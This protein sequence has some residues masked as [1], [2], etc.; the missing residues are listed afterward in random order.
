MKTTTYPKTGGRGEGGGGSIVDNFTYL[1]S[2]A[3][4]LLQNIATNKSRFFD[5]AV[6]Q[7]AVCNVTHCQNEGDDKTTSRVM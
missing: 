1:F 5:K 7:G 6:P 3:R 4:D 2:L